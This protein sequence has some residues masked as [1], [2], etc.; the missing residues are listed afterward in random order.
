VA[1]IVRQA[2]GT[3]SKYSHGDEPV[4]LDVPALRRIVREVILAR[5]I[6]GDF[7][8]GDG[9]SL[10]IAADRGLLNHNVLATEIRDPVARF[11][12]RI[13]EPEQDVPQ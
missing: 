8:T 11:W 13:D 10:A 4:R 9:G 3:R 2:Y 6:L 1:D 7:D 5:F 12:S